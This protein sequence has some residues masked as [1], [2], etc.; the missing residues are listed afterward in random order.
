MAKRTQKQVWKRAQ[1]II[2]AGLK[3]AK[4][5]DAIYQL[6]DIQFYGGYA[7]PGYDDP[8]CGIVAI[9][10]WNSISRYDREEGKFNDIDDTPVKVGRLL[11]KLGAELEWSDEW[12]ACVDCNKLVRTS[13]DSYGW[14]RSYADFAGEVMCLNCVDPQEW[15]E[16]IEGKSD[17]ANTISAINP[18]DYGYVRVLDDLEHGF[19]VGQDADPAVIAKSMAKLGV[20]R[21]LF[22]IDD[23]GQFDMSFSLWVHEDERDLLES[24][25]IETDG[26]SVSEAMKRGLK[27]AAL[28]MGKLDGDGIKYAKINADGTAT[29]RLVG[30]EE[31]AKGIKD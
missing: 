20:K 16:S 6:E 29:T 18:E 3:R 24:K 11:E 15:L 7:E 17:R 30:P 9:G 27:E 1:R 28:Q 31:F 19:H 14:Q 22:N 2:E 21:F 13:P 26:P 10:N 23:V 12:D 8:E 4:H 5:R 25:K